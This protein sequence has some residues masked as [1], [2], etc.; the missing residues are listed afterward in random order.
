MPSR[1][2][3]AP[4]RTLHHAL[5]PTISCSCA[6]VIIW[7]CRTALPQAARSPT[8][9]R[10]K[11]PVRLSSQAVVCPNAKRH[12]IEERPASPKRAP[13]CLARYERAAEGLRLPLSAG[14]AEQGRH[15]VP[16]AKNGAIHPSPALCTSSA[17]GD[18]PPGIA[19]WVWLPSTSKTSA[20]FAA[21]RQRDPRVWSA[22][23]LER[24]GFSFASLQGGTPGA[25]Q[26]SAIAQDPPSLCR[27]A[28]AGC[29]C[30]PAMPTLIAG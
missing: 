8:R 19:A 25:A 23:Q 10:A 16:G 13:C 6:T 21:A 29:L 18:W 15:G 28:P 27:P 12:R 26:K 20:S 11:F 30:S 24:I 7:S 4:T 22:W 9:A 14:C 2:T 1:T 3:Q 17:D 5:T